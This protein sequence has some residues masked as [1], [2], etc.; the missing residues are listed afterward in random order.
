MAVA[1]RSEQSVVRLAEDVRAKIIERIGLI[2]ESEGRITI[3][4]YPKGQGFD[5]KLNVTTN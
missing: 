4:L 2:M 5:I 3:E 1:K